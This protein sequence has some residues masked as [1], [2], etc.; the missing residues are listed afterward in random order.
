MAELL[1]FKIA[2]YRSFY[3]EQELSFEEDGSQRKVTAIFGPNS[4]GKSNTAKAMAVFRSC[5]Q[6]SASANWVLPYDPFLLRD[7]SVGEPT[8]FAARFRSGDYEYSYA[9]AYNSTRVVSES[10]SFKKTSTGKQT[11]VFTRSEDGS[12][13]NSAV[14]F[15]F[16]K[17]LVSKT[18][19]ETLLIT[20]GREDNNE[21]SNAVFDLVDSLGVIVGD[22]D[23]HPTLVQMLKENPVLKDRVLALLRKCDFAIRDIV[24]EDAVIPDGVLDQLPLD[25]TTKRALASGM[26][27]ASVFSTVHFVRDSES[28]VVN[29]ANLDFVS[30]ESMGTRKFFEMAVP[31]LDAL[32]R[33]MTIYIDEFGSYIHPTLLNVLIDLFRSDDAGGACL[34]INTQ[35]SAVMDAGLNRGDIVFVEKN[36][37][38][39]SR[40]STLEHRGVRSNEAF[41]KRYRSG[42]YGAVPKVMDR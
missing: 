39:E 19:Q 8:V 17:K 10:L 20:K 30:A 31:M 3:A 32:S 4:G 13:S 22:V 34:I 18:R 38:E 2:N 33:G 1:S 42:L 36:L 6:N 23:L 41:E 12:L 26:A 24:V 14:K 40:I 28:T 16:G 7:T 5:I 25:E 9:F 29:R 27:R 11:L 21:Y 15:G 37:A 35:N